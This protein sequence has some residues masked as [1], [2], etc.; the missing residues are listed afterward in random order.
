[1]EMQN[2]QR[3]YGQVH[4]SHGTC[5]GRLEHVKQGTTTAFFYVSFYLQEEPVLCLQELSQKQVKDRGPL[6]HFLSI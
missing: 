5:A 4:T 1:M 2:S 6:S 3:L